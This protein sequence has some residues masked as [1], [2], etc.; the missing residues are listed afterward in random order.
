MKSSA[1]SATRWLTGEPYVTSERTELRLDRGI[2]EDYEWRVD[3]IT[4]PDGRFG[5][6]CYFRDISEQ[7]KAHGREG[8]SGGDC[9]FCR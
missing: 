1:F 8:V 4:M 2:T 9:R 5:L 3:R 6:V 7:K